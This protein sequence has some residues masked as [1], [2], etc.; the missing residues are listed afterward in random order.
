MPGLCNILVED[1]IVSGRRQIISFCQVYI[2][3]H[4][5][6]IM[7]LGLLSS[8]LPLLLLAAV[9]GSIVHHFLCPLLATSWLTV[10]NKVIGSDILKKESKITACQ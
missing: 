4:K 5:T 7:F 2:V 10:D 9:N 1:H 3:S 6:N 8:W